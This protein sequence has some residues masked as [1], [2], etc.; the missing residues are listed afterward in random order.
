M[1]TSLAVLL[2][3][4]AVLTGC[5][6]TTVPDSFRLT[7]E[8]EAA[9]RRTNWRVASVDVAGLTPSEN[10]AIR[11]TAN[12]RLRERTDPALEPVPVSVAVSV[13]E[14]E[15][16]DRQWTVLPWVFTAFVFPG[17]TDT[18]FDYTLALKTP[19]DAWNVSGTAEQAKAN[20]GLSKIMPSTNGTQNPSCSLKDNTQ[21]VS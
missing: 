9:L 20:T 5:I 7:E 2:P 18:A 12:E 14:R 15:V 6:A 8:S 10:S 3:C 11:A 19:S 17:I 4:V 13:R 21:S 16:D 1:K